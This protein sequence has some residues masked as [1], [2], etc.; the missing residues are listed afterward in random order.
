M[1][2]IFVMPVSEKETERVSVIKKAG[3]F[4][5]LSLKSYG[6]PYIFWAYIA[7]ILA[8][9]FVMY[10]AIR[11]PLQKIGHSEDVI[12][13]LIY[14][15]VWSTFTLIIV[16]LL[17]ALFYE[18]SFLKQSRTLIIR[19]KIFGIT[20]KSK[21]LEL[22][23]NNPFSVDHYLDSPNVARKNQDDSLRAFQNQ[24]YFTLRVSTK[25]KRSIVID[26]HSRK[27]DLK[28]IAQLLSQY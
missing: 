16:F 5:E 20:F 4:P 21:T 19:H 8:T 22:E 7:A 17:A 3:A 24:G 11:R 26:R 1:G 27:A 14:Y 15:G 2:L 23:E 12:N 10:I 6:L 9:L 13:L 25:G 18:K 28:K